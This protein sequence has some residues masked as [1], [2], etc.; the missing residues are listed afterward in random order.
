MKKIML[1][2]SM[3]MLLPLINGIEP[4]VE[5]G[6]MIIHVL[7]TSGQIKFRLQNKGVICLSWGSKPQAWAMAVTRPPQAMGD[8]GRVAWE[9]SW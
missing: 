9:T 7:N 4:Q 8:L 3:L 1:I 2:L 6:K 5:A